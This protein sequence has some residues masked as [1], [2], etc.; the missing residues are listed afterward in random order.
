M[1]PCD[2]QECQYLAFTLIEVLSVLGV[3]SVLMAI[4]V[5]NFINLVPNRKAKIGEI[6]TFLEMARAEAMATRQDVYVCFATRDFPLPDYRYRAATLFKAANPAEESKPVDTRELRQTEAWL[7]L[8]ADLMFGIG[9]DFNPARELLP[10]SVTRRKFTFAMEGK[11]Y[12]ADLPY[13]LFNKTGRIEVPVSGTSEILLALVDGYMENTGQRILK[14]NANAQ[15]GEF[16]VL[17]PQSG[18]I[19]HLRE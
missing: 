14:H 13:L 10:D 7:M 12:H 9:A 6:F 2:R 3:I 11:P 1:K 16:L 8:P 15:A 19:S 4:V 17:N 18:K 5:P